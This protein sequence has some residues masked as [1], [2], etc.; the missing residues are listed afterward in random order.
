M[1]DNLALGLIIVA[2]QVVPSPLITIFVVFS[3]LLYFKVICR[4]L[5]AFRLGLWKNM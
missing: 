4:Q 5:I 2:M 1:N 3:L